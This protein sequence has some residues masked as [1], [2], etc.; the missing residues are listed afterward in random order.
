MAEI[1]NKKFSVEDQTFV[2]ACKSIGL[3]ATK[4]QAS[5][6]RMKKGKAFKHG[7]RKETYE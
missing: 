6:W 3:P 4:R 7:Q 1:T 5:K 2:D